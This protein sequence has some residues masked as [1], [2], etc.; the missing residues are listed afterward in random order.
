MISLKVSE[1]SEAQFLS[2]QHAYLISITLVT[3]PTEV[4]SPVMFSEGREDGSRS[5]YSLTYTLAPS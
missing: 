2:S 3:A 1:E 4:A 5:D